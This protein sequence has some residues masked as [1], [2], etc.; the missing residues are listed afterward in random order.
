MEVK[1][2]LRAERRG[3]AAASEVGAG[4]EVSL[5][6]RNIICVAKSLFLLHLQSYSLLILAQSPGKSPPAPYLTDGKPRESG[7]GARSQLPSTTSHVLAFHLP[8]PQ[9]P[10]L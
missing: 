2:V 6:A 4:L 5:M 3:R 8:E 10:D 1:S 7:N 9:F